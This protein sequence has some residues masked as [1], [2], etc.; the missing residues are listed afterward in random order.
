MLNSFLK[1]MTFFLLSLLRQLPGLAD[2][3]CGFSSQTLNLSPSFRLSLLKN[4]YVEEIKNTK[5]KPQSLSNT[6]KGIFMIFKRVMLRTEKMMAQRVKAL[7][8][9]PDDLKSIPGGRSEPTKLL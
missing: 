6:M 7:V 8:A 9:E 3:L 2:C 1:F 5:R 4:S